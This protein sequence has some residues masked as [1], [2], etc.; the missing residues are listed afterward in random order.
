MAKTPPLNSLK[1]SRDK[2]AEYATERAAA[3]ESVDPRIRDTLLSLQAEIARCT[4]TPYA[5]GRGESRSDAGLPEVPD[6][7]DVRERSMGMHL[8]RMYNDMH[9]MGRAITDT[10]RLIQEIESMGM[11]PHSDRHGKVHTLLHTA[12]R[13]ATAMSKECMAAAIRFERGA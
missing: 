11:P 4:N 9:M 10:E 8:N 2:L 5:N 12:A 7:A 1:E 6:R 13:H 3:N